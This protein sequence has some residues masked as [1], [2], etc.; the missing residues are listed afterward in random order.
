MADS[1]EL[2]I[3]LGGTFLLIVALLYGVSRINYGLDDRYVRIRLGP[4]PL[5]KIAIEDVRDAR[6]GHRHCSESWTNTIYLPTIRKKAVTL[7][8]RSGGFRRVVLTPD[9]PAGF[10]ERV[11][12]H[13]RFEPERG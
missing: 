5:R 8:R 10:V 3:G 9:D 11:K 4:I 12:R 1:Q 7:Y 13:P 6:L 2:I